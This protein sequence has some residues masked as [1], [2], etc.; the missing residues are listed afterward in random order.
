[1]SAPVGP[2]LP[3]IGLLALPYH[4]YS[5]RWMTPHHVLTRLSTYFHVVWLE[6][7]LHWREAGLAGQR[8]RELWELA[9]TLPPN[10]HIQPPEAWLPDV[11]RPGTL[12]R[13]VTRA[14]IRR[15]WQRLRFLGCDTRVIHLWHHRFHAAL[16][17][18]EPHLSLYHIDDEYSFMR[19]PG[20]MEPGERRVLGDVDQVFAISPAL[21]QRKGGINTHMAFAPE[22]VDYELYASPLPEPA[23]MAGLPHPR[24]GY[25][26]FLKDQLDWPLLR[27]LAERHP[28]WS[29]VFVGANK[30]TGATRAFVDD[31][32]KMPNVHLLGAK[33]VWELAPYPQHFDVCTMPYSVTGYTHNI[34]PLK[35]HEYLASGRPAVGTPIRS[36]LDFVNVVG[37]AAGV[38]EWSASLAAALE[39]AATS[40]AAAH[41]RQQIARQH[42]WNVLVADIARTICERLGSRFAQRFA[43]ATGQIAAGLTSFVTSCIIV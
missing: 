24:I 26:G 21:M 38:D 31:M 39:P 28:A 22:G 37:V 30:T 27:T 6:P 5:T 2:L 43:R 4:R 1:V 15:A 35:L 7:P 11:H 23:D 8:L 3:D 14:R 32:A 41:N 29:F 34:Y 25:T 42:D 18:G 16:G 33:T 17:V 13:A 12:S 20:P 10:F 40:D 36:L 19:E 9:A